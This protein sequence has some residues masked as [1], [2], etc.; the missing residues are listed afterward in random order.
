MINKNIKL[1]EAVLFASG[2]PIEQNELKEKIKDKNNI[3]NY[4][5]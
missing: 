2:E 5:N 3:L 4:L 1:L